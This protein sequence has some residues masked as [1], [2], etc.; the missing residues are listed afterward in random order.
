MSSFSLC[1]RRLGSKL[2]RA[3]VSSTLQKAVVSLTL[4]RA[5]VSSKLQRGSS[6]LVFIMQPPIGLEITEGSSELEITEGSSEVDISTFQFIN[7]G[8]ELR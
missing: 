7:L 6:E 5:V 3:V 1:S 8:P 4:Q 2:Q